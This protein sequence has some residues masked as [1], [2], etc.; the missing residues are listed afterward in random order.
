[1]AKEPTCCIGS[2]PSYLYRLLDHEWKEGMS[3]QEAEIF[4]VMQ[5]E[6]LALPSRPQTMPGILSTPEYF[7]GK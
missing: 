4:F 7:P 3:Q 5:K 1:M 2:G 6:I